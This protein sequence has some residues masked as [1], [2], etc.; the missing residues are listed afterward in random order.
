MGTKGSPRNTLSRDLLSLG[1]NSV[2]A[3]VLNL[4]PAE[5]A[6]QTSRAGAGEDPGLRDSRGCGGWPLTEHFATRGGQRGCHH[7]G[8]V[9]G[10]AAMILPPLAEMTQTDTVHCLPQTL[11]P[12]YHLM[13]GILAVAFMLF[14]APLRHPPPQF[15][16]K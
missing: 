11:A 4:V 2:Q 14:S 5:L 16:T 3:A 1:R 15:V 8:H 13:H 12:S 9:G 6:L 10:C 7:R